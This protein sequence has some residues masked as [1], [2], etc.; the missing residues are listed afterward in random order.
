M[1][2]SFCHSVNL[3]A[4]CSN[5]AWETGCRVSFRKRR[6]GRNMLWYHHREYSEEPHGTLSLVSTDYT[7]LQRGVA[8]AADFV[9]DVYYSN[10][11]VRRGLVDPPNVQQ[12]ETEAAD[13]EEHGGPENVWEAV[14]TG[15]VISGWRHWQPPAGPVAQTPPTAAEPSGP[16][17]QPMTPPTAAGP[18]R[19]E[20][21]TGPV[22][23]TPPKAAARPSGPEPSTG[24]VAPTPPTA[25]GPSGRG[26]TVA[27]T[28]P[29]T[30][31]GPSTGRPVAPTPPPTAAGPSGPG[32]STR[33]VAQTPPA[34]A[35]PSSGAPPPTRQPTQPPPPAV[36]VVRA[37]KPPH[38]R[39][40]VQPTTITAEEAEAGR[41]ALLLRWRELAKGKG[42]KTV[43]T[44][45]VSSHADVPNLMQARRCAVA[46]LI[47]S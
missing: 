5:I 25:A 36:P 42:K 13:A 35:G 38:Q 46:N 29:P 15:S 23:R 47:F 26:P 3:R 2:M 10:D 34:T 33:P 32:A 30:A 19:P 41:G 44:M 9:K 4:T 20:P 28:Q 43:P 27:Q 16:V 22:P 6:Q 11:L 1:P 37:Q 40:A 7:M 14:V 45:P 18:S 39:A 31:A 8:M 21:R 24:P 12:P 17:A